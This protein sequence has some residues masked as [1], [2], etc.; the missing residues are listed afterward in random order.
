MSPAVMGMVM[1]G[2]FMSKGSVKDK[3]ATTVENV[4]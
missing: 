1:Y 2:Y 4:K 3:A